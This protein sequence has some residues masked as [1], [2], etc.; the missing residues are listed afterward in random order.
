MQYVSVGENTK[1][2]KDI[3]KMRQLNLFLKK[4]KKIIL[5]KL[6]LLLFG[7]KTNK[8]F[9]ILFLTT[10]VNRKANCRYLQDRWQIEIF[11]KWI[12]Q[13][14]KIKTFLNI[15]NA[16]L[17]QIWIAM[18]YY[19]LLAYIKVQTNL[20]LSMLELSRMFAEV[21]LDRISIIDLLS[22]KPAS[23]AQ[24]KKSRASPQLSFF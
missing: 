24:I 15:K 23:I 11:F 18:I 2:E 7:A 20:S 22:L 4:Q 10:W 13:N 16:V 14:L 17:S 6:D 21:F 5:K 12:K 19:L 8:R 1:L 9:Y 3:W